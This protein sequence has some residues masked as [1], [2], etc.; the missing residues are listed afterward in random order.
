MIRFS[1]WRFFFSYIFYGI[2][3]IILFSITSDG[4]TVLFPGYGGLLFLLLT[5]PYLFVWTFSHRNKKS[6]S[7]SRTF[8]YKVLIIQFFALLFNYGD[9]QN[10][11]IE[12]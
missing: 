3:S 10:T 7:I 8:I 4:W 6:I 5:S 1:P 12:E 9:C 11:F 2:L